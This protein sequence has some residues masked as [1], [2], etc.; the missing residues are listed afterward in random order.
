MSAQLKNYTGKI[1][2]HPGYDTNDGKST[3]RKQTKQNKQEK[4][5][6][7]VLNSKE[8]TYLNNYSNFEPELDQDEYYK[9]RIIGKFASK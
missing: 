8:Q 3:P 6:K 1:T 2:E 4:L 5:N 7:H 9:T